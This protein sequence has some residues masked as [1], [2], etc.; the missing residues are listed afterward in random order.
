MWWLAGV[1]VAVVVACGLLFWGMHRPGGDPN[2]SVPEQDW[3]DYKMT[4]SSTSLWGIKALQVEF[5]G[6]LHERICRVFERAVQLQRLRRYREAAWYYRR[7][8]P[9]QL[10]NGSVLNLYEQSEVFR[11]NW[12]LLR[13]HFR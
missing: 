6:R 5:G 13:A 1:V 4:L 2:V 10:E 12:R 8:C 11:H 9:V 7:L 3:D